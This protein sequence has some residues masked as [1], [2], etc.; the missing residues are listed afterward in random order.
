VTLSFASSPEEAVEL[1]PN[2]DQPVV[3]IPVYNAYDDVI[4]C[5][6]AVFQHTPDEVPVLVVDDGGW[7]R[8]VVTALSDAPASTFD[9]R[10]VVVLT[11]PKNKGFVFAVNDAFAAAGRHDVVILNSDVIVGPEWL[12]RMRDAAYSSGTIGT[13]TALTNNGTLVSVSEEGGPVDYILGG[14]S[15][16]EA[17][18]RVAAGSP[19]FRPRI[20]TAIGH[21]TYIKRSLLDTAGG[22]DE[23]FSPGYGEEVDLSQRAVALGFEHVVADDVFVFHKGGSSFGHS[24]EVQKRRAAND[25]LNERR[26]PYYMAW[27]R[28]AAKDDHSTLAASLLA[29]RV[30]L[31]G[32][33]VAVDGMCLKGAIAGTQIAVLETAHAL[34]NHP[35]VSLVE[36]YT[37]AAVPDYV[38]KAAE[39]YPKIA[40]RPI[41][42]LKPTRASRKADVAFRPYQVNSIRELRW[43]RT[44]GHRIV[45]TWLDLIAYNNPAYFP[46]EPHWHNYR[47]TAHLSLGTADGVTTIS[48]HVLDGLNSEGLIPKGTPSTVIYC[49][50]DHTPERTEEP[51]AP[52]EVADLAAGYLLVIGN[53]YLHKNR[54]FALDVLERLHAKGWKG[55]CVLVG[56]APGS[57]SSKSAEAEFLLHNPEL[58]EHIVRLGPVHEY[59]KT[60]L[61]QNAG[62]VLY[63]TLSEGFG[64]VPFEA[65][66]YGAPCLSSRMGSL[67]EVL[68]P[69]ITTIDQFSPEDVA[70]TALTLLTDDAAGQKLVQSL[71][72]RS[73]NFTWADVAD[74]AVELMLDVTKRTKARNLAIAGENGRPID[75]IPRVNQPPTRRRRFVNSLV[76]QL[77]KHPSL[78]RVVS[79][80][81]SARQRFLRRLATLVRR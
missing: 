62:L 8:R 1:L 54:P 33:H 52:R 22:F 9:N 24:P 45:V 51:V 37:P 56:A 53:S 19:Q 55:T 23:T 44:L 74:R 39:D 26:Y 5:Y 12:T 20:P 65:A 67:D 72:S 63:P 46:T 70:D 18:R 21:C 2:N 11:E 41:K 71:L 69:D 40:L 38:R 42:G 10:D 81:G 30:S 80:K 15:P 34:A 61:Y 57:G 17:A 31:R 16:E 47:K 75:V 27:V 78:R 68:G 28:R 48:H 6:Q 32:L 79:P 49:G 4:Q 35:D 29:A 58:A 25:K 59:E 60:W 3:A 50:V 14:L 7:D 64:L 73:E 43:L 77:R 76:G 66:H 13:V 36:L